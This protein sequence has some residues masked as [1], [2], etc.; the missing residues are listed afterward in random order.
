MMCMTMSA[1][2]QSN[3]SKR[4]G[5]P[6]ITN[7]P[8]SVYNASTQNWSVG[9]NPKGFVYFGNNDGLMEFDGQHWQ[10]YPIPNGSIIR[11]IL[12]VNDTVYIGAFEECGYFA[13][14]QDG[15]MTYHSLI[16]LI[17]HEYRAFDEIW[18]IHRIQGAILF[19]SFR[20]LLQ[21]KGEKLDVLVPPSQFSH[22]YSLGDSMY[23][24]DRKAGLLL[25]ENNQLEPVINNQV[26]AQHEIRCLLR[27]NRKQ[28]LLGTINDGVYVFDGK[29]LLPW[30]S[31]VNKV[32][33]ENGLFSAIR[34]SNGNFAFGS[35]QNGL[36]ISDENGTIVQQINRIRGLQNNTILSLFEDRQHNLWLGL[37][38]GI[39][40]IEISSP[41]SVFNYNFNLESTYTTLVSKGFWYVGT[42]QG[43]YVA[44][45]QDATSGGSFHI[46]QGTEGQVW[47]LKEINGQ[48]FCGHNFGCFLIE[49]EKA[50]KLSDERGFWTIIPCRFKPGVYIAGLYD[51]LGV[52]THLNNKW[53]FERK[54][55]G[56]NVS[57]KTVL[58]DENGTF[59]ISHGYRGLY[60]LK[61]DPDLQ[62]ATEVRYYNG[63]NGLPVRL[64]YAIHQLNDRLVFS[65]WEGFFTYDTE[66][67]QFS[68][69][70]K[71]NKIFQD[72]YVYETIEQDRQG[73]IWYF[74]QDF[75]GVK[76]LQEDGN[77]S[78]ITAPFL[79]IS[80]LLIP[81]FKSVFVLDDHHVFIGSQIGLIHYDPFV[82]KNYQLSDP[83]YFR[84]ISFSK[85]ADSVARA[86]QLA[87]N[88]YAK[89]PNID[90]IP[91]PFNTVTFRYASPGFESGHRDLFAY[92]LKGFDSG[93]SSW[94][95]G[96]FKE[97][98]NLP[99]GKYT[100]EI[101][102][103][104]SNQKE[105][106]INSFSFTIE[107]PFFRSKIAYVVYFFLFLMFILV[108]FMVMKR[109]IRMTRI[110]ENLRHDKEMQE[111]EHLFR[112]KSLLAEREIIGLRNET[113]KG[114]V[115]YK[116][117]ELA[118]TTQHLIHKNKILHSI[119]HQLV[120]LSKQLI[121][122]N[123]KAAIDYVIR[124]I[125]KDLKNEKF[126]DV[127]DSYFDDVHQDFI[128]RLKKKHA[129]LSPKELRLCAYLKMNLSSKQIAPLLNISVRGVEIGRYRL[130]KKLEIEREDNLIE[131]LLS[132]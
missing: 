10:T 92:R 108:N 30:N 106:A 9:Q 55:E 111:Q 20:F 52:I 2:E 4:S 19:Q 79:K 16:P 99:Q 129:N 126:Q 47:F 3:T 83:V 132:I 84:E 7:Y 116:N 14:G 18:K 81:A 42:N 89:H 38:N 69:S 122:Q 110:R 80:K 11:S 85:G 131:Y 49:D 40:F 76:R 25:F 127:F 64:P 45:R 26:F 8:K 112:E 39:D 98:T 107:P 123:Q 87:V 66:S 113:L 48:V 53:K 58:Q 50:V 51:G 23:V 33:R 73:N 12:V 82:K 6:F 28:V 77:Y 37:D 29:E 90:P 119:K 104:N 101:K 5:L 86:D 13:P 65:T 91:Y 34:L 60:S 117:K 62:K 115:N 17:P 68:S 75:M 63:N 61:T 88:P 78:D 22:S 24:I 36:Y 109:R 102:A 74:T 100:F 124:R 93:W 125:N 15:K 105:S 21:F 71:L 43:L 72:K 130:R 1:Q 56:F 121:D 94:E 95:T 31:P 59:W 35:V 70:E 120:E 41:L 67:N 57:S 118:N 96:T 114:E 27:L 46:I 103:L 44:K 54:I 32:L 97:Y 128:D